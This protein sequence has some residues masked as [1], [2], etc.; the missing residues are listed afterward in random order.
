MAINNESNC[1]QAYACLRISGK[2]VLIDHPLCFH[3]FTHDYQNVL[4]IYLLV[5]CDQWIQILHLVAYEHQ[6]N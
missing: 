6:T 4:F 5:S 1:L 3:F 2:K